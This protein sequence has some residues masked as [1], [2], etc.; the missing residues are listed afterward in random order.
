VAEAD[1]LP[2][3]HGSSAGWELSTG[4]LARALRPVQVPGCRTT[5]PPGGAEDWP[6]REDPLW[7]LTG[8]YDRQWT[9]GFPSS[10]HRLVWVDVAVPGRQ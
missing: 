4:G 2:D 3:R 8:E 10:D 9:N 1:R 5:R 6:L 7:R